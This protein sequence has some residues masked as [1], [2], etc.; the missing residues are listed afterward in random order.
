MTAIFNA[1]KAVLGTWT[2]TVFAV[3]GLAPLREPLEVRSVVAYLT[4]G[5][6]KTAAAESPKPAPVAPLPLIAQAESPSYPL[7]PS[8]VAPVQPVASPRSATAV[9]SEPL[10]IEI[11]CP[12]DAVCGDMVDIGLKVTGNVTNIKW[13][14]SRPTKQ[15]RLQKIDGKNYSTAAILGSRAKETYLIKVTVIGTYNGAP[16][17]ITDEAEIA[18]EPPI[19]PGEPSGQSVGQIQQPMNQPPAMKAAPPRP[20]GKQWEPIVARLISDR[21]ASTDRINEAHSVSG[22]VQSLITRLETLNFDGADY[23]GDLRQQTSTMLGSK[24][25]KNWQPF[26]DELNRVGVLP[27]DLPAIMGAL[28]RVEPSR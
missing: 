7:Q 22:F 3:L 12:V 1:L 25:A 18:F 9:D 26:F 20:S 27:E 21:V 16:D 13:V 11:H 17:A 23:V 4:S 5:E 2:F 15:F 28:A 6:A 19:F 24:T 10:A 14:I 8:P